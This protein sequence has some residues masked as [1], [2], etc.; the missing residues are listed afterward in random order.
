MFPSDKFDYGADLFEYTSL[1]WIQVR[2]R[3]M[4]AYKRRT[5][6]IVV[7]GS[8][9]IHVIKPWMWNTERAGTTLCNT[10]CIRTQIDSS[11]FDIWIRCVW[12]L[13]YSKIPSIYKEYEM[14][15]EMLNRR[16][17]KLGENHSLKILY[18]FSKIY[19]PRQIHF[20][21]GCL[22]MT[23]YLENWERREIW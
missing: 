11:F 16:P 5:F 13:F 1:C 14:N 17:L 21:C 4:L 15:F 8:K 20:W 23:K 6:L 3:S 9:K 18:G 19:I 22:K 12:R 7:A 10:T 2:R